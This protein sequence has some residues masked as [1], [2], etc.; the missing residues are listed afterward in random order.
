MAASA[1]PMTNQPTNMV[2]GSAYPAAPP[3]TQHYGYHHSP[4]N[5]TQNP[6]YNTAPYVVMPPPGGGAYTAQYPQGYQPGNYPPQ[7]QYERHVPYYVN[8]TPPIAVE[9]RYEKKSTFSDTCIKCCAICGAL[10][11]CQ[12]CLQA[13][14]Y[15]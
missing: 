6:N 9:H 1:P 3:P 14:K 12:L 7:Q 10:A 13:V 8:Q 2:Y 5:A 4:Y 11:M 15:S